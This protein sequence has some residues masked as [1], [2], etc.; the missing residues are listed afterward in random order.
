MQDMDTLWAE[1]RDNGSSAAREALVEHYV[2]LVRHV[3]GRM[4]VPDNGCVSRDDLVGHAI[5]GLIDAVERFEPSRGVRF[6]TYAVV[7][8]RGA[9]VDTLRRLD[10]VP[11]SLRRT[12]ASLRETY[13]RL[14]A[15]LGRPATDEEAAE[16]MGMTQAEYQ[17]ALSSISQTAV[18]SLEEC[19]RVDDQGDGSFATDGILDEA[20]GPATLAMA[21]EQKRALAG[22]VDQLPERERLVVSLY[23]YEDLTLKEIGEVLGVSEARVSQINTR[24]VL[25]LG[26][27]LDRVKALFFA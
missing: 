2:G 6:E 9:V 13:A 19:L 21:E 3:V 23:Y 22:A 1:Y 25:R 26:G 15:K 5:V 10:W 14:E 18:F 20:P 12:E 4:G 8:I 11:R 27:K 7:R 17:E 24:A 16:A